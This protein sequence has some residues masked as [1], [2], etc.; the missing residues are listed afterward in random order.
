MTTDT[1]PSILHFPYDFIKID[2]FFPGYAPQ[3]NLH[4]GILQAGDVTD[5]VVAQKDGRGAAK[6]ALLIID[7]ADIQMIEMESETESRS[8]VG[9][10]AE[11]D[12]GLRTA[13]PVEGVGLRK[14]SDAANDNLD[15]VGNRRPD[16]HLV[17]YI[18]GHLIIHNDD[19]G[20]LEKGNPS[21]QNLTMN[22][23]V[24]NPNEGYIQ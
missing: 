14:F 10:R 6:F 9:D 8:G 22:Q 19:T 23:P 13:T 17:E 4:A 20:G 21:F 24:V 1:K 16:C 15:P 3:F 18:S 5:I 2:W 12:D 11:K 7:V